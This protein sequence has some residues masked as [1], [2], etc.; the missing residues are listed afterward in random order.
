MGHT[1]TVVVTLRA[2]KDLGLVHQPAEGFRVDDPVDIPLIAGT[3]IL[4][5]LRFLPGPAKALIGKSR[6]RVELSVLVTF[7]FFTDGHIT[8]SFLLNAEC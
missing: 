6:K 1:G 5:P 3:D 4:H 7:Q 8:S 2:Q